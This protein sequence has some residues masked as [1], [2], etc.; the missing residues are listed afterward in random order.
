MKKRLPCLLLAT[1]LVWGLAACS[2]GEPPEP[3]TGAG[4]GSGYGGPIQVEVSLAADQSAIQEI[5][6]TESSETDA[7]GGR[8]IRLL[9]DAVLKEQ[10]L[11]LDTVSGAT[12]AS[13]GFLQAL[14]EAL[15]AAGA[16]ETAFTDPVAETQ[17]EQALTADVVVVGAGGAGLTAAVAAARAGKQVVVL[18][19]APF[20][21]GN[22]LRSTSGMN[23]AGTQWQDD[24]G[25]AGDANLQKTLAA[26]QA[27][28]QLS[29]L[30]A[31]IEKSF[32][33]WNTFDIAGCFDVPELF[34]LDTL[35]TGER[36]N[37]PDLVTTLT[38]NS[39][40][41]LSWLERLGISLPSVGFFTGSSV[42]RTHRPVDSKGAVLPAGGYLVPLLEQACIDNGVKIICNAPVS[43]IL[44]S[45]GRV[46]G[47]EADGY[48]VTAKSVVLATGGF[49]ANPG[50]TAEQDP[51]LM[52]LPTT[53]IPGATGDGIRMAQAVGA[54]TRDMELIQL[55][56]IV[57][58]RTLTPIS[59]ELWRDG[60]ILVN[61]EGS[62]FWDETDTWASLSAA[63]LAQPGGYA[64]LLLDQRMA[65]ASD[66]VAGYIEKGFAA[67]GDSLEDLAD[68]LDIPSETLTATLETWN[69]SAITGTDPDFGR[70]T[71]SGILDFAPF[72]AIRVSPALHHTMGGLE[73]NSAAEVQSTGGASIPGL[74]AAG[75]VT[76]GLHGA[77]PL[78]GNPTTDFIVFGKIAGESAAAFAE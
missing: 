14:R 33:L 23:A 26:A 54:A 10:T 43:D 5:R 64:Y 22:S 65:D 37:D 47:V 73:I 18:E 3:I 57:E 16:S 7:I 8:A 31:S 25:W 36:R 78:E 11:T 50:L 2:A 20:P 30:A 9:T 51:D 66:E 12:L 42:N 41:T 68:A 13:Q 72:Y 52:G 38:E 34:A 28:P 75:E 21:G 58:Q 67:K 63:E 27:Y 35:L 62:R 76:G 49:S 77:A 4:R 29:N 39:A 71:F 46:V 48:T 61:Q 70:T 55:H 6:V 15:S 59:G 1:A 69:V 32:Q 45:G 19:K 24:N 56:P 60:A 74:F 44:T 40:D 53:N 17:L